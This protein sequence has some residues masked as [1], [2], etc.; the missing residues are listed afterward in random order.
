MLRSKVAL[1]LIIV[2]AA[3]MLGACS[4]NTG[5][6]VFVVKGGTEVYSTP[7]ELIEDFYST[8]ADV[9]ENTEPDETEPD[10]SESDESESAEPV[11]DDEAEDT[12][13]WVKSG[14]V[15]HTT[16]KCSSLSRSKDIRSGSIR[17]AMLAGKTRVCKRCGK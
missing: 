7:D 3:M 15:W 11:T 17:D 14:E 2:M 5:T 10:E 8:S 6:P 12:V 1:V 16:D 4:D 9:T 13:Y